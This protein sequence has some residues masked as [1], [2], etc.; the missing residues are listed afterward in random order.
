MKKTS[1]HIVDEQEIT[2]FNWTR[3]NLKG[4]EFNQVEI[5]EELHKKMGYSKAAG[6]LRALCDGA[7]PPILKIK[8][9]VYCFNPKPVYIERLQTVWDV[10][11][12]YAN[13]QNYKNGK[14]EHHVSIEQAIKVL[15]DAGYKILKP[16]VQYE[17]V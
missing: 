15:K 7:N 9:G 13:P 8:R 11:T 1:H 14:H 5:R 2:R 16:T 3:D 12:K 10:Y 4:R 6:M 17:E